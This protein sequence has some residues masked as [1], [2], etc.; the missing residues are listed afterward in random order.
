MKEFN[1]N[2]F[3]KVKLTKEGKLHLWKIY[4]DRCVNLGILDFPYEDPEED[5]EGYCSFQMWDFMNL[6]GSVCGAGMVKMFETTIL[7][8][9]SDLD[10]HKTVGNLYVYKPEDTIV[11]LK[12]V[13]QI[14]GNAVVIDVLTDVVCNVKTSDLA[15][16]SK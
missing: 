15:W 7:I 8:D 2:S 16:F 6:F 13:C 4:N 9:E 14:T 12:S 10:E 5:V 3:V 1:V 11:E